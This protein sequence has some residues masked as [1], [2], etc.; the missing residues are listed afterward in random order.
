[1]S[2]KLANDIQQLQLQNEQLQHHIVNMR[3]VVDNLTGVVQRLEKEA[4]ED[5]ELVKELIK[6][7]GAFALSKVTGP[8]HGRGKKAI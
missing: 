4:S 7:T 6:T 1:M 3:Q 5:R 2:M 8:T